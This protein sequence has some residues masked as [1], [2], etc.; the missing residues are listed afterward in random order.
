MGMINRRRTYFKNGLLPNGYT[1]VE[2]IQSTSTG[3]QYIDLDILL[4]DTLNKNYDIAI[5]FLVAG[6]GSDNNNQSTMFG[7]QD[8]TGSPW[9]GTFIR[10]DSSNYVAK[11][12]YIGDNGKDV[13]LGTFG[14]VIELP[15]QTPPNKNVY[16]Y[17]NSGKTHNWGTSL[18]CAFNSEDKTV[19][20]RF[21]SA[22]LYYFKLF[23]EGVLVRNMIP[24]I[25]P[26]NIVGLFDAAGRKFY[27]SPNGAAFVAGPVVS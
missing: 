26:N 21:I 13:T 27:S 19:V 12:R 17:N 25:S 16:N 15:V 23:V 18:F 24:C 7:C 6:N 20:H 14:S 2:Y 9:P 11:G 3:S 1:Q 4:Y 10:R 8:N 5:K 22:T